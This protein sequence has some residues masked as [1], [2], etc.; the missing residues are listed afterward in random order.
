MKYDLERVGMDVWVSNVPEC[1]AWVSVRSSTINFV[2]H[3]VMYSVA[4]LV[5]GFIDNSIKPEINDFIKL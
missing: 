2:M 3:S 1:A 4:Y 5:Y